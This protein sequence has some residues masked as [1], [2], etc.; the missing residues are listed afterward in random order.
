[1]RLNLLDGFNVK[2]NDYSNADMQYNVVNKQ[3]QSGSYLEHSVCKAGQAPPASSEMEH[4]GAQNLQ[5]VPLSGCC[6]LQGRPYRKENSCLGKRMQ[7][8]E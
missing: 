2:K 8:R 6:G 3:L 1:M 7:S 5:D 4:F